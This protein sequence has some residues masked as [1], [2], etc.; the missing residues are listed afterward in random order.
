MP[1][2][3]GVLSIRSA[4]N[5]QVGANKPV[6][7]PLFRS[8][9]DSLKGTEGRIQLVEKHLLKILPGEPPQALLRD[10]QLV[11]RDMER[12]AR[13]AVGRLHLDE[14]FTAFRAEAQDIIAG[15]VAILVVVA[16]EKIVSGLTS[17][18]LKE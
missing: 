4:F 16:Q 10:L 8:A 17:G 15:A 12:R 18:A 7:S 2:L 14:A 3:K 1:L 13:P 5:R 11:A 6:L 9:L